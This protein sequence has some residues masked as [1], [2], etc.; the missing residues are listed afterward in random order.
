ME[1]RAPRGTHNVAFDLGLTT[2]ARCDRTGAISVCS[3]VGDRELLSLSGHGHGEFHI[4]KFS[5]DGRYLAATFAP[6]QNV[7]V[8][9]LDGTIV[10]AD[11]DS[12]G[13]RRVFQPG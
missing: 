1:S 12:V 8:V 6:R 9:A 5:P 3:I 11:P 4:L 2:Y 10:V 13:D 7:R